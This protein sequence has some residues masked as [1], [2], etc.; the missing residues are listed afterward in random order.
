MVRI[1]LRDES[2]FGLLELLIAMVILNIGLFAMVGAFNAASVGI[3]RAADVSAA[4]AVADKQ[5]EIYRSLQD[6]ALW[7]DAASFPVKNSGSAYQA[8]TKAYTDTVTN[9]PVAFFDKSATPTNQALLPWATSATSSASNVPWN[10]DIPSSCTLSA[11]VTPPTT[12]TQAIQT[13]A[14]PDGAT[15]PVYTYIILTQPT[16]GTYVKQVTIVVRSPRLTSKI[17]ARQT[18]VFNP[19]T[20]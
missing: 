11:G 2:G 10:G 12:A 17:L 18:S 7:L 4:T 5:M 15:Y 6:C 19:I 14:G 13:I 3:A 20:S 16:G 9:S 8:D 1:S